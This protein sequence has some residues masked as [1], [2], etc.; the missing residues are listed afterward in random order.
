M[1]ILAIPRQTCNSFCYGLAKFLKF[2]INT[3]LNSQ[4][5]LSNRKPFFCQVKLVIQT[6]HAYW[7]AS[8]GVNVNCVPVMVTEP[9]HS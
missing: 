4:S 5:Q 8:S 1:A 7:T 9:A 2:L 3:F 6:C